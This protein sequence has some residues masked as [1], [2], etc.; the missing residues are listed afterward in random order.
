M[1]EKSTNYLENLSDLYSNVINNNLN[2]SM[3]VLTSVSIVMTVPTIISGFWGM[4]TRLP[5]SDNPNAFY[6][7]II[8]SLSLCFGIIYIL[9]KH[10]YI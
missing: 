1:I 6:Y 4:N 7:L 10:D 2:I 3:K 9:I 8:L 5:I